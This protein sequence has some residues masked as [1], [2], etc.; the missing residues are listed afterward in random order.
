M[1]SRKKQLPKGMDEFPLDTKMKKPERIAVFL[2]W[3]AKK[4]PKQYVAYNQLLQVIE[5]YKDL[6]SAKSPELNFFRNNVRTAEKI[7]DERFERG[8]DR[9]RWFGVRAT[10]DHFDRM[11]SRYVKEARKLKVAIIRTD[12]EAGKIDVTKIPD[13]QETRPYKEW[14][15]RSTKS[16]LGTLARPDNIEKLLP[17]AFET[18]SEKDSSSNPDGKKNDVKSIVKAFATKKGK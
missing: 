14:F 13:T 9:H 18:K 1:A 7:L 15:T 8:L 12:A 6:P 4:S 10:T 16:I 5:G 17:Q 2:D 3:W 11:K